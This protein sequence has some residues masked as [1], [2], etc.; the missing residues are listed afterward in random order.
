MNCFELNKY[1]II[2]I[3]LALILE[4]YKNCFVKSKIILYSWRYK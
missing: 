4:K 1:I 2:Q 3:T